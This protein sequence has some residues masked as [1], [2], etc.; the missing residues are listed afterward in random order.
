VTGSVRVNPVKIIILPPTPT[1][2]KPTKHYIPE[3]VV[4]PPAREAVEE[5][6]EDEELCEEPRP[7]EEFHAVSVELASERAAAK[8]LVIL[9]SSI[10]KCDLFGRR[11]VYMALSRDFAERLLLCENDMRSAAE[12]TPAEIAILNT[13]AA[14]KWIRKIQDGETT[15]YYGLSERTTANLQNQLKGRFASNQ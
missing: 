14:R 6:S 2:E 7:M 3:P 11:R 1:Q 12:F 10:D 8:G 5:H 9:F 15:Y 13:L 4:I